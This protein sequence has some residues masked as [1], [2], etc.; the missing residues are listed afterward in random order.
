MTAVELAIEA[1]KALIYGAVGLAIGLGVNWRKAKIHGATVLVPTVKPERNVARRV[2][3]GILIV[4]GVLALTHFVTFTARQSDCN[5]EFRRVIQERGDAATEQS[6]L[7]SQLERELAALGP[8][9]TPRERQAEVDARIRYVVAYE[10]AT[11]RRKA[12]PYPDPRC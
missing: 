11:E 2:I 4:V 1:F 3:G 8:V 10:Q 5:E 7:W 12:N 9:D 6:A